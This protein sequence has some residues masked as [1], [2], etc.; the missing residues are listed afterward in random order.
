L[1]CHTF[2]SLCQNK[3]VLIA[4]NT[5]LKL[6]K[7]Y[8]IKPDFVVCIETGDTTAQYK[9]IDLSESHLIL[10]GF[11][12]NAVFKKNAKSKIFSTK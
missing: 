6:L 10:E 3:F 7:Q 12:A 5:A 11:C 8:D 4:V 2:F 9:D 1:L